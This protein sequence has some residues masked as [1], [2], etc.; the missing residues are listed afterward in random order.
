MKW[1]LDFGG[2][3]VSYDSSLKTLYFQPTVAYAINDGISIGGGLTIAI[4]SVNL[5]RREDLATVPLGV[6]PGL[7][8]GALVDN[9]TDFANTS[10]RRRERRGSARTSV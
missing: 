10:L 2:R 5:T 9:Q 3:F 8:F 6:V 1:P 4:S 7:T